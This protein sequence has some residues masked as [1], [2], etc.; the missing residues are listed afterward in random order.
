MPA[1]TDPSSLTDEE[2]SA[3][4]TMELEL[5][6]EFLSRDPL[7]EYQLAGSA[8]VGYFPRFFQADSQT[9][10]RRSTCHFAVSVT[11]R[12]LVLSPREEMFGAK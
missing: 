8:H 12:P 6:A 4:K 7:C 3:Y 9:E 10:R 1:A 11:G 2:L 5:F